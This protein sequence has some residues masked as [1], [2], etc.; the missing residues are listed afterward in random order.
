MNE[1]TTVPIAERALEIFP[2]N[3]NFAT[4]LEEV[5]V[6]HKQLVKLLNVLVSHLAF[7]ADAPTLNRIFDELKEYT[8]VHFSTEERIWHEHFKT[9]PWEEWH[10]NAHGDFIAAV[11]EIKKK[12]A[13]MS[14]DDVIVEIVR[15]LTH[16]LALHI[17]ESDKRMAKVVLALP[18]GIS[19]ERAKE[20]AN[21][22]M[23]GSTRILIKTVMDM[24]DTLAN[25]TVELTREISQ[26]MKA[27]EELRATQEQLLR[28]KNAAVNENQAKSTFLANMSHE[29]RTPMSGVIGMTDVLLNTALTDEQRKMADVIRDSAQAQLSILN[30]ILD[31]SKIEADKLDLS[32]GPFSL[33][34]IV[35]KTCAALNGQARQKG[36][37]LCQSADPAIPGVLQGDSLRVRQILSN[38][39]SNAIKFSS[40]RD[41][42][43]QVELNA[44]LDG[45]TETQIWVTLSVRDNGI[46]MDA[47][48]QDRMFAPFAQASASTPHRYG[49]TGLGLVISTRLAEAM[50]GEIR[51]ESKPGVGSTFTIRLPFAR[52]A[53]AHVPE[54][55][56][57]NDLPLAQMAVPSR[58]EA[59]RQGR[60]I[61]VAEDNKINQAVIKHQ[62]SK[63]GYQCDIAHDGREAF[64][65]WLKGTYSFLL[66][67]LH[68]PDMDGYQLA[69][70]IR[71]KEEQP[72]AGHTPILALS[73]NVLNGEAE[74]CLDVG[75]DGY[76]AKPV[77]LA[78]LNEE[79]T[80]RLPEPVPPSVPDISIMLVDDDTF[81]HDLVNSMLEEL[82]YSEASCYETGESALTA[83]DLTQTKPE[84]V[85]LDINMPFMD[86]IQFVE[87]LKQRRFSGSLVLV[88][89]EDDMTLRATEKL[90]Q[91]F[92]LA[93]G[94]SI[95][96]PPS[97]QRLADLLR[98]CGEKS[99][100]DKPR[101]VSKTYDA[102]ALHAAIANGELVNYYQPKVALPG[103]EW[104]GVETLVRW[105]HPKDGLVLP[106]QFIPTAEAN[107]MICEVTRVVLQE[108][109]R[110]AR[111]WRE[112]GL[113][114]RVAINVS[115][116]DLSDMA[117]A[118][119]VIEQAAINDVPPQ[120]ITLEITE[121]QLMQNFATALQ[122]LAR[123]RLKRFRLSI[124]DFGTGNSSL[125]QLRDLPFDELK[126]DRGFT[127][128][129]CND[130]RLK[131][132]FGA[133]LEMAKQ[134]GM[135][136]VAEGVEDEE[137]WAFLLTTD[138]SITQGYFVS[139]P[140]PAEDLI[141]WNE[142]WRSRRPTH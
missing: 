92:E 117:F 91:E 136:V 132:I 37:T 86:G 89:G 6:Q 104:I 70:A 38:I 61:L 73:A 17:I 108:S 79:L 87:Q 94:G 63:L 122:V 141:G 67:D 48:T 121:G 113:D 13:E 29:I 34:D 137:D 102:A 100:L 32:L 59:I 53:E 75:M 2:W 40:G 36:V 68:M 43:G 107:G 114:L 22:E 27:E 105:R 93:V 80:K 50:G 62:L 4:G 83:Y 116:D 54:A 47:A 119:F 128:N 129:A 55:A 77:S 9:D 11:L 124:D 5:D 111:R 71:A 126:I 23:A 12:E 65:K 16:W 82:G 7:N 30:D 28:M 127:H 41:R 139:R 60:L 35:E 88:S 103:G 74:R 18:S 66:T 109:I 49:G 21:E 57:T 31:F 33:A 96:K 112:S 120:S 8:V 1:Q 135:E 24:Y 44:Q 20:Q 46:G 98:Q 76:M 95:N 42:P 15:F 51:V 118:D 130:T 3:E 142:Q 64:E 78:R 39:V 69:K 125:A 45:E 110:Q 97:L 133:S 84:I 131:A 101:A 52:A 123:L 58:D 99:I 14:M 140:L 10:K 19:L 81:M 85:L 72:G 56:E 106:D 26:R 90:A 25:R 134:L 115:V 138:T